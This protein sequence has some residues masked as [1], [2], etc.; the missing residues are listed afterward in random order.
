M[1]AIVDTHALRWFLEG[2]SRL[3]DRARGLI[4]DGDNEMLVSIASLWEIAVKHSLGKLD[5]ARPFDEVIP[6]QLEVNG[7]TNLPL[8]IPHVAK[9][10]SLPFHHRDPFDRVLIAQAL[11]EGLPILGGDVAFDSYGVD[12]IW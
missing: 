10:A 5:L 8:A 4:E 12:R 7:F 3:P 1:R 9:V 6:S 2:D 11:V